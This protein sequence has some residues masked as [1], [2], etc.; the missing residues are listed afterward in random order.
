MALETIYDTPNGKHVISIDQWERPAIQRL[1]EESRRVQALDSTLEGRRILSGWLKGFRMVG[2]FY[3]ASTRTSTSFAQGARAL[4]ADIENITGV[5]FSSVSKGETLEDTVRALNSYSDLVVMRH[6]EKGALARAATVS[7]TPIINAGDGIGEHPTQALLD[8]YTIFR[9]RP[10]DGLRLT[11]VGDLKNG[12]TVHSLARLASKFSGVTLNY[13]SP[14]QLR[15]PPE[16]IG[17]L[18]ES[19]TV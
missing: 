11:F 18:A 10:I 12:R 5:Q 14:E 15:M 4:G 7:R 2:I 8:A 17:Q 6:P 9:H 13:V 19:G 16:L 1:F 3:E